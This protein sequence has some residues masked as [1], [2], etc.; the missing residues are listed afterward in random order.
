MGGGII[1]IECNP[2]KCAIINF[3]KTNKARI[4]TMND[5]VLGCTKEQ[6]DLAVS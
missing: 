6:R 5:G 3:G 4:Y 1:K 2:E